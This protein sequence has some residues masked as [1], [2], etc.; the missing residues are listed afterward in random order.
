LITFKIAEQIFGIHDN[1][2]CLI[3]EIIAKSRL[4]DNKNKSFNEK[5]PTEV[6]LFKTTFFT[7][8]CIVDTIDGKELP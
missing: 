6:D 8:Y 4:K 3:A 2:L 1:D 5:R 7:E